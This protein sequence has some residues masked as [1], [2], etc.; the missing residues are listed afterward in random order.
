LSP[1]SPFVA[2]GQPLA[3]IAIRDDQDLVS[4]RRRTRA[5]GEHLGLPARD[6]RSFSAAVYE[7]AR[8]VFALVGSAT[9]ELRLTDGPALQVLI[10]R[11]FERTDEAAAVRDRVAPALDAVKGMVHRFAADVTEEAVTLAL[12]MRFP[13]GTTARVNPG[14]NPDVDRAPE[15]SATEE[16]LHENVLL[17]RA[18]QELQQELQETNRGVIAM[19]AELE[20]QAERLRQAEDRLRLLLD[21]V[22][23]Y[24][25]CM[26]TPDGEVTSWN[27]GAERLFGYS[28][29]EIVGRNFAGF[30][31]LADRDMEVPTEQLRSSAEQGRF[32]CECLRVRRGGSAFDAHVILTA[33][34]GRRRELRGFSLVVRDVTERKRLENDLRRR[35]DELAA[36]NRA[37]EEFLATL[38]HELRTPLNAMLGWTRL[39]RMGKLDRAGMTRALETIERNAHLQ[40]QLIADIL[41]VSRIVTG[42]LRLELRPMPLPPILETAIDAV[43][44]AADAKGI[45]LLADVTGA[46]TVMADPDRLQQVIWNLLTNAIKFTASGGEIRL[47]LG[48][49]GPSAVVTVTDTGEGIAPELLP[50]IFD[51]F[52]QGDASVTRPHGGLGLGLSIV[53]HIVEL[54]GGKVQAW[55]DGPGRGASFSVFLPIRA[56]QLADTG[57]LARTS[58]PLTGVKVL[59]VD[60]D[61]DA[62]DVV[63]MALAQCGAR[64]AAV[65]SA[66]EALQILPDFQPD[67]LVSDIGM[68]GEDGY[69][70]IRRIRSRPDA[71]RDVPA[72]ALTA[73]TSAEDERRARA[74]GFQQFVPKPVEVEA[75]AS[76]VRSLASR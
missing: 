33:V 23:D 64:T 1:N 15:P 39:L 53:R 24:A 44:P 70:L 9:V 51:R 16:L 4:V 69:S 22:R 11:R 17:L 14:S 67:V 37:K 60:D 2:V 72:V 65:S 12:A 6:V 8:V 34:E 57:D 3:A 31:P 28:A 20:D 73:F 19:Y 71:V 68:P 47:S 36:A 45:H 55:S 40:E 75:L 43:R 32:E 46:G 52:T 13:V 74:A 42:K 29:D 76:V 48:R 5:A 58:P 10:H 41:D 56:V 21:G 38:S 7:A 54:H 66:Q 50:Y 30:Y 18:Q 62:R 63:S 61:Q 59:V 49:I 27:A 26:L 25:I 35:A